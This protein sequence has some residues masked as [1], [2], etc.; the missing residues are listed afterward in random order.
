MRRMALSGCL[1]C[2]WITND[3]KKYEYRDEL[4]HAD[5]ADYIAISFNLMHKEQL[6]LE[7]ISALTEKI[8]QSDSGDELV[9]LL[10]YYLIILISH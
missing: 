8:A 10:R 6:S 2:A 7:S 1:L 9:L 3:I 5:I 4:L